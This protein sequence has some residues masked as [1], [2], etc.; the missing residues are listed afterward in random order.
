MLRIYGGI[1]YRF[2]TEAANLM[3]R[4][5]GELAVRQ[6]LRA[7]PRDQALSGAASSSAEPRGGG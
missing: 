4:R 2:S 7:L 6:F 1:H 3:G 5:N